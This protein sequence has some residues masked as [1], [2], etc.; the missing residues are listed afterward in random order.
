MQLGRP[1]SITKSHVHVISERQYFQDGLPHDWL[2][3]R[4]IDYHEHNPW[5]VGFIAL[6]PDDE[7]FIYDEVVMSPEKYV[8]LQ[9]AREVAVHSK[10]FKY[11]LS[12]IDPLAAKTQVNTGLSTV[13]DLNRIFR[14]FRRDQIGTGGYWSTWDTKST[15]GR[16]EIRK[17]LKNA[18][19]CGKPFN[20]KQ[21][22]NGRLVNLPTLWILSHCRVS[23]DQMKNWRLEEWTDRSKLETKESKE[24]PMQR[25]SHMNTVWECIAKD[26]AFR[27]RKFSQSVP[28]RQTALQYGVRR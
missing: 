19:L 18:R 15:R 23:I 17:R 9:I 13:D 14:E 16:E 28:S 7:V 10:D 3:S 6:S 4:G 25:Y 2:H 27:A 12:L 21:I 20:N 11:T 26:S 8:T 1:V 22:V 5:H 24:T